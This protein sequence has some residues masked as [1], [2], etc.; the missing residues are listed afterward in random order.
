MDDIFEEIKTKTT[1]PDIIRQCGIT[2]KTKGQKWWGLCPFHNDNKPSLCVWQSSGYYC[3]VC[4]AGG[5]SISF[6]ARY[7]GLSQLDAVKWIAAQYNIKIDLGGISDADLKRMEQERIRRFKL[8]KGMKALTRKAER[9]LA[10]K[11]REYYYAILREKAYSDKWCYAVGNIDYA[12]HLLD[13]LGDGSDE[14]KIKIF[15]RMG[16]A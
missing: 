1:S 9:L 8:E 5:D 10:V 12:A 13:V 11:H 4:G 14:D 2:L 7:H 16:L 3:F 15:E 6:V